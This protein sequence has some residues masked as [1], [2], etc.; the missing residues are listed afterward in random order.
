MFDEV[1]DS[2]KK[3]Y[4]EKLKS[5][6]FSNG[7]IDMMFD[8]GLSMDEMKKLQAHMAKLLDGKYSDDYEFFTVQPGF[9]ENHIVS[10][11]A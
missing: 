3:K 2:V 1:M 10:F 7:K 4:N 6:A 8:K 9:S 5:I 11:I